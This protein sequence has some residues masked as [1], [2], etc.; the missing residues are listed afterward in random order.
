V[1]HTVLVSNGDVLT[2]IRYAELLDFHDLHRADATMAVRLHEWQNPFGVVRTRGI[3]IAGFE[4]KPVARAYVN[5]GVYALSPG[6][7][8]L[9]V[10]GEACNMPDLFERVLQGGRRAIA[11]PMHE[12]WMD[13]G[14]PED[15]SNALNGDSDGEMPVQP[16]P[17]PIA[18]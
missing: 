16:T 13:I 8:D 9:L 14:R 17:A 2:D 3:E 1:E 4:E 10:P 6:T 5:A 7:L 11:Y 15:Y 12:T 18:R